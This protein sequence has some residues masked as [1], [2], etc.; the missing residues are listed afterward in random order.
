M[1]GNRSANARGATTIED[2]SR[3]S[4]SSTQRRVLDQLR[5]RPPRYEREPSRSDTTTVTPPR[6]PPNTPHV[7]GEPP[8]LYRENVS[9]TDSTS[10]Q[11][12]EPPPAYSAS[13][14]TIPIITFSYSN[15]TGDDQQIKDEEEEKNHMESP[16]TS[17]NDVREDKSVTT[18][19]NSVK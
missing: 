7:L 15:A 12:I 13:F 10:E 18:D 4:I 17:R 5:D 2:M 11:Q 9:D 3:T 8:P 14:P 6:G 19:T 16:S 1:T